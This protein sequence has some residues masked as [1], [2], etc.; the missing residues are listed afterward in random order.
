MLCQHK[1]NYHKGECSRSPGLRIV[2]STPYRSIRGIHLGREHHQAELSSPSRLS[3]FSVLC[4]SSNNFFT[5]PQSSSCL[6]GKA[7]PFLGNASSKHFVSRSDHFLALPRI[8]SA[9]GYSIPTTNLTHLHTLPFLHLLSFREQL[10]SFLP[11][12]LLDTVCSPLA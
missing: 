7:L 9:Q 11:L 6:G 3:R 12:K 4:S 2:Q 5:R 1:V 10:H 8:Q